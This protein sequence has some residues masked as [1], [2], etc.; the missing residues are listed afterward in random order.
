M[1]LIHE[2]RIRAR[3]VIGPLLSLC[4]VAYFTFH[5]VNGERGLIAWIQVRQNVQV[6]G[7]ILK[8]LAG[9]RDEIEHRI[10]LLRNESLDPDLLDEQARF[11][12]NLGRPDETV[13]FPEPA[14]RS[15]R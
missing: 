14:A 15:G 13:I 12:L 11:M 6:A 10:S 9:Q 2:L 4:L 5:L 8:D 1:G 7:Q 3:S